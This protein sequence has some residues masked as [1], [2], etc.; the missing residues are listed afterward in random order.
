MSESTQVILP[1]TA[2]ETSLPSSSTSPPA[3]P[4]SSSSSSSSVYEDAIPSSSQQQQ[5]Q[6]HSHVRA[7]GQI[8]TPTARSTKNE[9]PNSKSKSQ[10]AAQASHPSGSRAGDTPGDPVKRKIAC[11]A[12]R[13]IK[14]KCLLASP[15]AGPEE[16]CKRCAKMKLVCEYKPKRRP[17][18]AVREG[19]VAGSARTVS[20]DE[21]SLTMQA[22]AQ[23]PIEQ[24]KQQQQQ[25]HP[26]I[27][28]TTN[29]LPS[30]GNM[31][32]DFR[33]SLSQSYPN[34]SNHPSDP[35]TTRDPTVFM[36][37]VNANAR[38]NDVFPRT[39]LPYTEGFP[40]RPHFPPH[41]SEASLD[42]AI[43]PRTS[44]FLASTNKP[45][46]A[47]SPHKTTPAPSTTLS[48]Y[49]PSLEQFQSSE[50]STIH[51]PPR[52]DSMQEDPS[53]ATQTGSEISTSAAGHPSSTRDYQSNRSHER[54][55]TVHSRTR[56]PMA[57]TSVLDLIR[58]DLSDP[59]PPPKRR[60]T[61]DDIGGGSS[62]GVGGGGAGAGGTDPR[63]DHS[64]HL[65]DG[66]DRAPYR[67]QSIS[68]H[69]DSFQSQNQR[70]PVW[71]ATVDEEEGRRP[72][73]RTRWE[74]ERDD[75]GRHTKTTFEAND[76]RMESAGIPASPRERVDDPVSLGIIGP[77]EE[78]FLYKR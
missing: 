9:K 7:S 32:F 76:H 58:R 31:A 5:Q 56:Y 59:P 35:S 37:P 48:S 24:Q 66:Q 28:D 43:S 61:P 33:R 1:V 53:P 2:G 67:I 75:E 38:V 29:Q 6:H 49:V 45:L 23:S 3:S 71:N 47:S 22:H 12:C 70:P 26:F 60:H 65:R 68:D 52:I 36:N 14:L 69:R 63:Q 51:R 74:D 25:Q 8:E 4:A 34:N 55:D 42:L 27:S 19:G 78:A 11:M 39:Q 57:L 72:A 30:S 41:I 18:K 16:P 13:T 44:L 77:E 50:R 40:Y 17:V 62:S 10:A 54:D 73:K 46:S 15:D 20:V 64:D 21:G